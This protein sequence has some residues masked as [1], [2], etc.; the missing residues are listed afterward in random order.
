M[1]LLFLTDNFPPEVN[2]PATRTYEHCMEWKNQGVEVTVITCAPNFPQGAVYKGYKNKLYQTENIDGIKVIR[3][4]SYISPN[5]GF[6]KRVLDYISFAVMSFFVA[7]FIKTDIIIATSPQF[8]AAVSGRFVGM[9]KRKPWI[10]EVRDLWPESIKAVNAMKE[11]SKSLEFL[12]KL[13]LYLYKKAKA[14]I[15][16]TDSFKKNLVG[17]GV[18]PEKVSVVKNG[19]HLSKFKPTEKNKDLLKKLNLEEN[20]VIGYL[21]THGL[22]HKLDFILEAAS[23]VNGTVHFLFIGDGAEKKNLLEIKEKLGLENITMLPFVAKEEVRKYISVTDVALV[24]LKKSNTFKTVIPSKIFENASMKK[25]I[26]LGVEGESKE[27][28]EKYQAGLCF[29]PENEKD[30]LDKLEQL[31]KDKELYHKLTKGCQALAKDYDRAFLANK[32]LGII[33]QNV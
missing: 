26:L 33:K 31:Y 32:M 6:I 21:G 15:V 4:W 27:I 30:F 29:E 7:L 23:K 28:V 1:K 3:V 5:K 14:I 18:D 22:A 9:F 10:M 24:P 17:R 11:N 25:P 20:F 13:E 2:A 8:F 16:V 12:E 19:V